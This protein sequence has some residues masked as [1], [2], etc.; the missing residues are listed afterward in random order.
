[1]GS[2]P[3]A[4]IACAGSACSSAKNCAR[5]AARRSRCAT[6]SRAYCAASRCSPGSL[7]CRENMGGPACTVRSGTGRLTWGRTAAISLASRTSAASAAA[8]RGNL[9]IHRPSTSTATLSQPCVNSAKVAFSSSGKAAVIECLAVC[10][11]MPSGIAAS[12]QLVVG[13]G[14]KSPVARVVNRS[15]GGERGGRL[16]AVSQR[17]VPRFSDFA[18]T[19][20]VSRYDRVA[21][22]LLRLDPQLRHRLYQQR[23]LLADEGREV[24]PALNPLIE[25]ELV[26][27][28]LNARDAVRFDHTR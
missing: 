3:A 13:S 4:A 18:S 17:N 6:G 28:A 9:K 10:R 14:K 16:P 19:L 20:P 7:A 27:Q 22:R 11:L 5:T 2:A 23:P 24:L 1:M 8:S 25:A 12:G 26:D 21:A 15:G